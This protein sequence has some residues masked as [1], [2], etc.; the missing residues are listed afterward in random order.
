MGKNLFIDAEWFLNQ[1]VYL[2]GYGYNQKEV[3]QLYGVT[4]NQYAFAS[5]LRDVDAIYC[6][7][8]DIGMME[9]FFNC[10]LK[11]FYYCFNLLTIIRRLEPNL[12]SYKLSELEKIAGIKRRTMVYKSNIW[13]LHK[14]WQNPLK[15]HYAML[16]N[17]EDV[18]N[19]MKVKN[20]FF[21][22]HGVT[23]R[24]IVKYRL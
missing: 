18:V 20:F 22:R 23:R 13:Q 2:V 17:R 12:K 1:Q 3:Y 14:D 11:N 9:K 16:Y 7:G 6:Y 10:D 5:I 4:L 8:P 24:D 19:L 21:Q 15:R